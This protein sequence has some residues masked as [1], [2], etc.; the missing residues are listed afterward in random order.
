MAW[1]DGWRRGL[2]PAA[3]MAAFAVA[4]A[5][6]QPV[7]ADNSAVY[8]YRGADRDQRLLE[9]ARQEGALV[10][11]TSLATT[12]SIP[13][14]AAFE[15]KYGVQVRLWR[16]L[17]ESILQRT[18]AEARGRRH[19]VDVIETNSPEIEA[20][21]RE[22]LLAEFFSRHVADLHGWAVPAHRLWIG[23]RVDLWVVAFNTGQVPREEIPPTYEGFLEPKWKGRI[24]VEASDDEW[25]G[26][27]VKYWGEER[28]MAFFRKLSELKPDVRKG[29][30]LLAQLVA[31]G[32]VPVGLTTYSG[33]AESIKRKGGPI[34]WVAVE[35]LV[36][37]PQAIALARHAPHPN[38]ALLF[39]DF[40]L[41]PDGMQLLQAMGRVPT[42]R[43]LH[44]VMDTARYVLVDPAEASGE[45]AKWQ[46]IWK[47]LFLKQ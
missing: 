36:G 32:E 43:N 22:Q 19:D 40:V 2:A 10:L 14:I 16:A 21:A 23:D 46:R 6:A 24:A 39:A 42:S 33:N 8:L 3:I 15:R 30:V 7:P 4:A 25:L 38:A 9:M 13:L 35:P 5:P 47:E 37:R 17:S 27:V 18:V 31:A 1:H 20:L 45:A 29:H 34:D 12:E 28:G 41:S 26:A 44:T 11:Y